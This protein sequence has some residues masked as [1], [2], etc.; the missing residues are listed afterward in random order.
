MSYNLRISGL[1]SGVTPAYVDVFCSNWSINNWEHDIL[2]IADS[3]AKR[4]AIRS[5]VVPGAVDKL[6]EVLGVPH[7][8]DTTLSNEN[9]I[10]VIPMG[11]LTSYRSTTTIAVSSY[12]EQIISTYPV[13][14]Y[15]I[16]LRG[17]E[18]DII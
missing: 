13:V 2:V 15:L 16:R 8:Y 3:P 4:N 7:F 6:Y 1:A 14:G 11:N 17:Y 10:K 5:Y 9:T 18:P 12:E